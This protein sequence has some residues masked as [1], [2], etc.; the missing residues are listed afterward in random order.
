MEKSTMKSAYRETVAEIMQRYNTSQNGLSPQEAAFR[1]KKYGLNE[2]SQKRESLYMLF[3]KQFKSPLIYLLFFAAILIFLVGERFDAFITSGILLFNALIATIQ[4]GRANEILLGL[5]QYVPDECLLIRNGKREIFPTKDLVPGDLIILQEGDKVPADARIIFSYNLLVDESILTG[6]SEAAMKQMQELHSE[7]P[8]AQQNNLVFSGTY[9]YSGVAQAIVIATG[10]QTQIG[11]IGKLIE[12]VESDLP[13]AKKIKTL[14]KNIVIFISFQIILFL[15]IGLLW[16]KSIAE[17]AVFLAALFICVVP[18]GL[19]LVLTLALIAGVH[20][21]VKHNLLVKRLQAIEGLAFATTIMIDKTGTLTRNELCVNIFF[22]DN[23]YFQVT[24][25]GY[26]SQGSVQNTHNEEELIKKIGQACHALG[27]YAQLEYDRNGIVKIKGDP[28]DVALLVLSRKIEKQFFDNNTWQEI[29]PT[30]FDRRFHIKSGLYKKGDK[31][32]ALV[33]GSPETVFSRCYSMQDSA[34][35]A[36]KKFLSQGLRV[37]ALAYKEEVAARYFE[38]AID[39]DL[40]FLAVIALEDTIRSEAALV[41]EQARKAGLKIVMVTGDNKNT[42]L[43]I[44]KSVGI[45]KENDEILDGSEIL[46]MT[47]Q[48]ILEK[49]PFVRVYSRVSPEQK[50]RLVQLYQKDGNNVAMTGDGVND[51]P[52][53]VAANIGIAMGQNGTEVAK[54]AA[55]MVLLNDSFS[56]ILQAIKEGRNIFFILRRV[57]LYFFVTNTAELL[58]VFFA[59]CLNWPL[60]LFPAQILLMNFFTDG[61][62][63]TALVV[64]GQDQ[65]VLTYKIL[66]QQ[67]LVDLSMALKILYMAIPMSIVTLCLFAYY[68]TTDIVYA[69]TMLFVT[70]ICFQLFNAWNCRSEKKSL[71]MMNFFGNFWLFLASC[72]VVFILCCITYIPFLQNIFH[73]MALSLKELMV[74][75]SMSSCIIFWEEAR[76]YISKKYFYIE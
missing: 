9:I 70:L 53:L 48:E 72:A 7:V 32:I 37:I 17:L 58:I 20:R 24:G 45:F 5:K 61:L 52:A 6:E 23:K 35:E 73:T 59:L 57:V 19:P 46:H 15:G 66:H 51:A 38:Q 8:I 50:L 25:S 42:A 43:Y 36:L 47:D 26:S 71:F 22:A 40:T 1:L 44:A 2:I 14:T 39:S 3:L 21:M 49:L 55:D 74:I 16:G 10:R 29:I 62:L 64:E 60:P 76:K 12:G 30:T 67:N 13:L 41:I 56:T 4:E 69:R 65:D 34:K 27:D 33:V 28:T 31:T 63:N 18:E 68:Y 54:Q 11:Q 75:V